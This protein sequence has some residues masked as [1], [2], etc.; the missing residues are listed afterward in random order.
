[1]PLPSA[2][3]FRSD[4]AHEARPLLLPDLRAVRQAHHQVGDLAA[5]HRVRCGPGV[6]QVRGDHVV[7]RLE[8]TRPAADQADAVGVSAQRPRELAPDDAAGPEDGLH[9]PSRPLCVVSV[10]SYRGAGASYELTRAPGNGRMEASRARSIRAVATP[11][12]SPISP[13]SSKTPWSAAAARSPAGSS[14]G[15]VDRRLRAAVVRRCRASRRRTTRSCAVPAPSSG[16]ITAV[17]P[18][19]APVATA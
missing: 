1:P 7:R 3:L 9:V 16:T 10:L 6:E 18:A 17:R 8:L 5:A 12:P 11:R 15:T 2:T 13:R 4:V 14:P 19:R